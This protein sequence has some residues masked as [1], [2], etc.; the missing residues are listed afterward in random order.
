MAMQLG[1]GLV[2]ACVL[3]SVKRKASARPE[4]QSAQGYGDPRRLIQF[5]PRGGW[6]ALAGNRHPPFRRFFLSPLILSCGCI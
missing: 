6:Q 4:H 5:P 2:S 1:V 3:A